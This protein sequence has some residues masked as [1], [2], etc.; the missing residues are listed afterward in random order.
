V[1]EELEELR[2]KAE[3]GDAA[4]ELLDFFVLAGDPKGLSLNEQESK[5]VDFLAESPHSRLALSQRC[6]A[7]SPR[8]LRVSRLQETGLVRRSGVTPTDALHALGRYV[9]YDVGAADLALQILAHFVGAE[10]VV[11]AGRIV[12]EVQR[13]LALT[14]MRRELTAEDTEAFERFESYRPLLESAIS[15]DGSPHFE[16]RWRQQRP[17]VGIGAPVAAFLPGACERLGA[18]PLIP[19]HAD[20]ANAV[21][22][23]TSK[24]LVRES[25]RIRPGEFGGYVVFAPDS[26]R[27]YATLKE[28]ESAAREHAVELVRERASGFGTREERV[29]VEVNRRVGR[30]R[31]GS[32]QLLEVEVA[33]A[34]EGAPSVPAADTV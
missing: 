31:D 33:G 8:L 26:R 7:L 5:I 34:L 28:A 19:E 20:V 24:V 14:I 6:G 16:L 21:G 13:Q 15:D 25:V 17:V 3:R 18:R 32:T 11:V 10:P 23:V 4:P 1:R 22:A 12:D 2:E 9:P 30:V 27:E 29:S